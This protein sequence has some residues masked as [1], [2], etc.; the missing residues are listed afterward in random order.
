MEFVF[1][2]ILLIVLV[3]LNGFFVASEFALVGVRKTRI[4]ELVKKGNSAAKLVQKAL[5]N[6]DSY[7]SATQLGITLASLGLGWI[8]EPTIAHFIEPQLVLYFSENIAFLTAHTLAVIMAFSFITFLHIVLGELAPKTIALQR[9]EAT[10]MYI[11]IPL[12]AFTTLFKPFIWILNEA[13]GFVVRLAGLKPPS[14]HQLVHSE[15]EIKMILSQSEESGLIP[16]RE[17]E[18]VYNIFK[19]GDIT[20][21]QIMIPRTDVIAFNVATPLK[22]VIKSIKKHPHSRF[23]VYEHSID[24]VI[25]FIHVKDIYQ[26]VLKIDETKRRSSES[27]KISQTDIIRQIITVPESKKVDQVLIEMKKKRIH[28]AVVNDEYGG[29]TG[30]ITLEDVIESVVGEIE[31][32]FEKPLKG[33]QKQETGGYTI[34]GLTSVE[35]V[36]KKF[37]LPVKG[38]GYTTIGGLVFGLLGHEPR[39]GDKVQLGNIILEIERIEGK[40]I[41]TISLKKDIKRKRA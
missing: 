9:A 6:L 29:T 10:S 11:I 31:D 39:I 37:S 38:Q 28:M 4:D 19:L 21:K 30:L 1:Q 32:E 41:K 20:V 18:M 33:I 23:P 3:F 8:G 22:E 35:E 15:E 2:I 16:E 27:E 5:A 36:Q 26:E 24:T 34:D 40:R 7:I 17:V 12:T 25:G 14:G 13:G